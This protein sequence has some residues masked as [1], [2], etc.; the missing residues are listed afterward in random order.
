MKSEDTLE[1]TFEATEGNDKPTRANERDLWKAEEKQG[2][3]WRMHPFDPP[4]P[5]T[6]TP[7]RAN[8]MDF[9]KAE[10][11]QDL[12]P[13][14]NPFGQHLMRF[15]NT[16]PAT[17]IPPI[18]SNHQQVDVGGVSIFITQ[19]GADEHAIRRAVTDGLREG[20]GKRTLYDQTQLS[21]VYG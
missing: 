15:S 18:A 10:E 11:N 8:E 12:E 16:L 13:H 4:K 2:L 17:S 14:K 21:P 19:P 5:F 9:W 6:N 7:T 1:G 3:D 20:L